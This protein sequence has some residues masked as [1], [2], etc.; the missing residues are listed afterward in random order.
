MTVF[1]PDSYAMSLLAHKAPIFKP[2]VS[3]EFL[4]LSKGAHSLRYLLLLGVTAV[5]PSVCFSELLVLANQS[6]GPQDAKSP[7]ITLHVCFMK[8]GRAL[9]FSHPMNDCRVRVTTRIHLIRG[10]V[11]STHH[12]AKAV[13]I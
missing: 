2:K 11:H 4:R 1:F 8:Q 5:I 3:L 7:A 12:Y 6:S 10:F 9:A 13:S